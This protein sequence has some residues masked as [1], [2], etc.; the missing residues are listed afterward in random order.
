M[1]HKGRKK[2]SRNKPGHYAG[3]H[4]KDS[5][6]KWKY[7]V[8]SDPESEAATPRKR[9]KK[10][11]EKDEEDSSGK[12]PGP[13]RPVRPVK[14]PK[15]NPE[16]ANKP[17]KL[18]P[19]F[20]NTGAGSTDVPNASAAT[21]NVPAVPLSIPSLPP[22]RVSF[23]NTNPGS[24]AGP[25][26]LATSSTAPG[27]LSYE[28]VQEAESRPRQ[29]VDRHDSLVPFA[30]ARWTC[31]FQCSAQSMMRPS[32]GNERG[33]DVAVGVSCVVD[34][35]ELPK[36]EGARI[37][38]G[39]EGEEV[40]TREEKKGDEGRDEG[41]LSCHMI[42]G[43]LQ[44]GKCLLVKTESTNWVQEAAIIYLVILNERCGLCEYTI[45]IEGSAERV[46]GIVGENLWKERGAAWKSDSNIARP[47]TWGGW[48]VHLMGLSHRDPAPIF[49]KTNRNWFLQTG[50]SQG[51]LNLD[52][53]ELP[54]GV[55]L[56]LSD[57]T[58]CFLAYNNIHSFLDQLWDAQPVALH[59]TDLGGW[60]SQGHLDATV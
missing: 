44:E 59:F 29:T 3:G 13:S 35:L 10:C 5:G 17:M 34:E 28:L 43:R 40:A 55:L 2:G 53:S 8:E 19:M 57:V 47:Q 21:A 25:S 1:G 24:T 33:R 51:C 16:A 38:N 41:D 32:W 12:E 50:W 23:I 42:E 26:L 9:R 39:R 7:N 31:S 27:M 36:V 6:H 11:S 48:K 60:W 4:R 37:Q 54:L 30:T 15:T 18:Y 22:R 45:H 46:N 20:R 56:D 49:P 58:R 52:V 14:Q